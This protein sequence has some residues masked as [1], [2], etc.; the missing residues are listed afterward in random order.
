M[1]TYHD[2]K[3]SGLKGFGFSKKIGHQAGSP[4]RDTKIH[5]YDEL[6]ILYFTL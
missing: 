1:Q 5:D 3:L 6:E 2:D 4:S